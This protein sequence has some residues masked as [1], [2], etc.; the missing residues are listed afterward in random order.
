MALQK[1]VFIPP[2]PITNLVIAER[3]LKYLHVYQRNTIQCTVSL[4]IIYRAHF[5]RVDF[6]YKKGAIKMILM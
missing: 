6:F 3:E 2:T 4:S 1:I 5:F